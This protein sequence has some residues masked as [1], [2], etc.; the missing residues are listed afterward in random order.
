ME[1]QY[2]LKKA[3]YPKPQ[4]NHPQ[5]HGIDKNLFKSFSWDIKIL[6]L[7]KLSWIVMIFY[8]VYECL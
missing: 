6:S 8:L 3:T 4:H 5:Y 7:K 1:G 2:C